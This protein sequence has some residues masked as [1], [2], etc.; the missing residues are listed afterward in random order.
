M[1]TVELWVPIR[2][3]E[4]SYIISNFGF[5]KSIDRMIEYKGKY[6]S[7]L[8]KHKAQIRKA[9]PD[10]DGYPRVSLTDKN[11]IE[12]H[13]RVHRLVAEHF[14]SN[15]KNLPEVN[16]IDSNK[17]NNCVDN[18]EWCTHLNNVLHAI[19]NNN[20]PIPYGTNHGMSKLVETDIPIIRQMLKDKCTLMEIAEVFHVH[21]STISNIKRGKIW[22][23]VL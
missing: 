19:E 20:H 8:K 5:V 7:F 10:D 21:F 6:G 16:H 14:I 1:T 4:E 11:K 3:Y 9:T 12:I 13:H 18:L 15:P 23:H 17:L 22:T 2:N